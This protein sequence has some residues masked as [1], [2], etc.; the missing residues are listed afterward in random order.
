V[1]AGG[2]VTARAARAGINPSSSAIEPPAS[3]VFP[4]GSLF[5][6]AHD[7]PVVLDSLRLAERVAARDGISPTR[8]VLRLIELSQAGAREAARGS[9]AGTTEVPATAALPRSVVLDPV[10]V[11]EAAVLLRISPR[12]VTALCSRG[13]FPGAQKVAGR[14]LLERVD[15]LDRAHIRRCS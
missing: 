8:R 14:W 12:R 4:G 2:A 6:G 13:A 5:I 10:T 7:V 9:G 3:F 11:Q 1:L 15:V